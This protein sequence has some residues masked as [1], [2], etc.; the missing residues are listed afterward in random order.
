[1]RALSGQCCSS[2]HSSVAGEHWSGAARPAAAKFRGCVKSASARHRL[3][4]A[5]RCPSSLAGDA[6][7]S[8]TQPLVVEPVAE[9][10]P[11]VTLLPETSQQRPTAPGLPLDT[12]PRKASLYLL[13]TDGKSC[14]R[15]LVT[16][17]LPFFSATT[18]LRGTTNT[19]LALPCCLPC[20]N[21]ADPAK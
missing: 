17:G 6:Q 2:S 10:A 5:G 13:R 3:C 14:S 20:T 7:G 11:A 4:D 12:W 15:E 21:T 16:G 19:A 1:M 8:L 9:S 18:P